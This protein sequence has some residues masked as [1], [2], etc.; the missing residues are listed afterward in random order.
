MRLQHLQCSVLAKIV[1]ILNDCLHAVPRLYQ[2]FLEKPGEL[3]HAVTGE[4]GLHLYQELLEAL[5]LGLFWHIVYR[6][7]IPL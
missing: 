3:W 5:N 2:L 6:Y 4:P 7:V 1:V